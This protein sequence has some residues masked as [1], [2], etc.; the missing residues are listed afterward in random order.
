MGS[1]KKVFAP[2]PTPVKSKTTVSAKDSVDAEEFAVTPVDVAAVEEDIVVKQPLDV[3]TKTPCRWRSDE[4]QECEI[5]DRRLRPGTET[6]E[7]YVHFSSFNRRLDEWVG[8]ERFDLDALLKAERK[9]VSR[10]AASERAAN[11]NRV[12]NDRKRKDG[13][14]Q[15]RLPVLKQLRV[16]RMHQNLGNV[17]LMPQMAM[18]TIPKP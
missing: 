3:G 12:K 14:K 6:Y 16:L 7:Y 1:G 18:L 5:I 11:A 13:K 2:P 8:F 15:Q 9:K 17:T 10:K 4:V